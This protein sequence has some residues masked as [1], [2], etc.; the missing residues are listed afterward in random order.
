MAIKK[1]MPVDGKPLEGIVRGKT[2]V[3]YGPDRRIRSRA[4]ADSIFYI[5]KASKVSVIPQ[6]EGSDRCHA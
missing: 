1:S 2:V 6:R 3:E 5:R 4:R